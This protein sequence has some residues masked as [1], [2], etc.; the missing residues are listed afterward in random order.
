MRLQTK[1]KLVLS[2][3]NSS[4]D[5][6]PML[7]VL[8]LFFI[9]FYIDSHATNV[10]EALIRTAEISIPASNAD[11]VNIMFKCVFMFFLRMC[12]TGTLVS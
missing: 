2:L 11:S 7:S 6:K 9:Y 4:F 10:F 12:T 5:D 1:F 8:Y 3:H